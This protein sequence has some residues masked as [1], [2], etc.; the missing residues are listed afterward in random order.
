MQCA[1]ADLYWFI[2]CEMDQTTTR[3][4]TQ[5]RLCSLIFNSHYP[6]LHV[7]HS[8]YIPHS[9]KLHIVHATHLISYVFLYKTHTYVKLLN[10]VTFC[11]LGFYIPSWQGWIHAS[12]MSRPFS[13]FLAVFL[14][15]PHSTILSFTHSRCCNT[16]CVYLLMFKSIF[17]VMK[18]WIY[19]LFYLSQNEI[20]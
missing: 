8:F 15:C 11:S 9:Y 20:G 17:N 5:Q 12:C 2:C 7:V 10:E 14:L 4:H 19:F 3:D 6:I 18:T 1:Y 13:T 16:T